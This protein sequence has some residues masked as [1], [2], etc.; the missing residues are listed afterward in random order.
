MVSL[1]GAPTCLGPALSVYLLF[2]QPFKCSVCDAMA[3]L[4]LVTTEKADSLCAT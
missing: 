3:V 2:Q 4:I 1:P